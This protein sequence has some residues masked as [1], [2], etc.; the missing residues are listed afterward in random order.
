MR[1]GRL[2][3]RVKIQQPTTAQDP[4]TGEQVPGWSDVAT[5]WA[6]VDPFSVREFVDAGAEQ[7]SVSSR[8][9]MRY[10]SDV[11]AAMRLSWRGKVY[12]IHGVL[13]DPDSGLE[14]LTLPVSQGVDDGN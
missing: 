4:N 9:L 5:V 12:N 13:P 2:R 3:H 11:T 7:S 1:A 10:R 8:V 14:W 6:S